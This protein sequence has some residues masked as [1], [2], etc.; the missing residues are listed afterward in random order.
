VD[1]VVS[2]DDLDFSSSS[3][4]QMAL[5]NIKATMYGFETFTSSNLAPDVDSKDALASTTVRQ[6]FNFIWGIDAEAA[7]QKLRR[8]YLRGNPNA[9]ENKRER[10]L[11][12]GQQP[13][14]D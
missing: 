4:S 3:L 7:V 11:L 13:Q 12:P 6:R 9:P 5:K 8:F 10:D 2:A 1:R 14:Q